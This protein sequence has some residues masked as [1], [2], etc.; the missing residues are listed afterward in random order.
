MLPALPRDISKLIGLSV[1][2]D[3]FCD[4][5]PSYFYY[6]T[7]FDFIF[8]L[9][10]VNHC[11]VQDRSEQEEIFVL[12]VDCLEGVGKFQVILI[13]HTYYLLIYL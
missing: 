5:S 12:V 3:D 10:F 9:L 1:N 6:E 7:K 8:N 11:G 13:L 2:L 4:K